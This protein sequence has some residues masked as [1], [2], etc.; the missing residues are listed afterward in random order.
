L[1]KILS[2]NDKPLDLSLHAPSSPPLM[3]LYPEADLLAS[4]NAPESSGQEDMAQAA[5][6]LLQFAKSAVP[7]V[8]HPP[9]Y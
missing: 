4:G 7:S 1:K 2:Q 5:M 3:D 8:D 6:A 9:V